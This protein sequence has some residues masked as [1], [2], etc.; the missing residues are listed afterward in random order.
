MLVLIV[1]GGEVGSHLARVLTEGGHEA[2]VVESRPEQVAP[3]RRDLPPEAVTLGSGTDPAVLE[4]A[5][6]RRADAVAAVTGS[7]ESNLVVTCLARFEF[8]VPRTVA[9]VNHP[10]H[11]WMFSAAMG[12]DVAL[13]EADVLAHLITEQVSLPQ[14]RV[15]A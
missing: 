1:G 4:A 3:L 5:A 10:R 2:R 8:G 13:N 11:A 7:D 9:R 6:V 15:A 14:P 12:V